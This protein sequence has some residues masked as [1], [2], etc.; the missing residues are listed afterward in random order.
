LISFIY[1]FFII[2]RKKVSVYRKHNF[3]LS[4]FALILVLFVLTFYLV[5]YFNSDA[6]YTNSSNSALN[7]PTDIKL[8]ELPGK[9]TFETQ[10]NSGLFDIKLYKYRTIINQVAA[11]IGL[12]W[13]LGL[14]IFIL[15]KMLSY[16]GLKRIKNNKYNVRSKKWERVLGELSTKLNLKTRIDILFSPIINSP[17]TFGFIK[18]VILFPLRITTGLSTEEIKCILIHELAHNLRN[19]YLFNI[20]QHVIESLFFYHPGIWWMTKKIRIHREIICDKVVLDN[21][22]PERFYANTLLKLSELQL[23]GP[24][25]AVAAKRSNKELFSRIKLIINPSDL[26]K[27]KKSN[28]LLL[29]LV[30]LVFIISAFTFN[31]NDKRSQSILLDQEMEKILSGY[32]GAFA[33]YDVKKDIYYSSN[34]SL[35]NTRYPA[36][37]TFKIV[38][39]LIALDMGIA[40]DESYIIPY[41]SIKYPLPGWM[42][43]NNFFKNWYHEHDLKSALNH[44]VNWYFKELGTQIGNN[45]MIEYVNKLDYGDKNITPGNNAFWF[46][47][48]LKIS[49]NEQIAFIQKLLNNELNGISKQAQQ[50]TKQLF[51]GE[52]ETAYSLYGKTGTGQITDNKHIGWY[53]GFLETKNNSYVYALNIS[54][55]NVNEISWKI[56]QDIVTDIFARLGIIRVK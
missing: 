56:R 2:N 24:T 19:D 23:S 38:S 21:K 6:S 16:F 4:S 46:N 1:F 26:G 29:V 35:C 41:D 20:F 18:P 5:D 7:T 15:Q 53:V 8:S 22:I 47:G 27:K 10:N 42:K 9:E 11:A 48:Q 32:N 30:L 12:T 44:S 54:S 39:S 31:Q 40:K 49:A 37:S 36:Y 13:L 51:P 25:F 55:E 3:G 52:I 43:E 33:L 45:R 14:I 34:D 50:V 17:F 28:P